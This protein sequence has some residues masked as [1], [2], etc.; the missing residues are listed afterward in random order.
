MIVCTA[1]TMV[2]IVPLLV[3]KQAHLHVGGH[4]GSS[5]RCS[6]PRSHLV[7]PL[8]QLADQRGFRSFDL[9][10]LRRSGKSMDAQ[11]AG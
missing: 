4:T 8:C 3:I 5:G 7:F 6:R 9:D 1:Q 10:E 11:E 2:D